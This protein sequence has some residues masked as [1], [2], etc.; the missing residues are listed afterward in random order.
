MNLQTAVLNR[1]QHIRCYIN[2]DNPVCKI[3]IININTVMIVIVNCCISAMLAAK[4]VTS[5][6]I[7]IQ[8]IV[9]VLST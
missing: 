6:T 9:T 3:S 5:I 1:I 8:N 7:R 2:V 4:P